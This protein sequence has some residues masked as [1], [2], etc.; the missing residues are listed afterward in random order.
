MKIELELAATSDCTDISIAVYFNDLL[1]SNSTA[2]LTPQTIIYEIDDTPNNHALSIIMTGKN[3]THTIV[4][5]D[6]KIVEDTCF[7]INKLEFDELDMTEIFC[8][9]KQCYTHSFNSD[10]PELL[11]EFYGIIGCNGTVKI[12]FSTPVYLWLLDYL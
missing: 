3:H 4:G 8:Q 10:G 7:K 11:D 12:E 9:G 2:S 1:L 5:Q 6:E